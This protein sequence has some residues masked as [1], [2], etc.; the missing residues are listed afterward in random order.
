MTPSRA[1]GP[2]RWTLPLLAAVAVVLEVR[3]SVRHG[4]SDRPRIIV[5][6]ALEE[7]PDLFELF[8]FA[9][10][11]DY[12]RWVPIPALAWDGEPIES[13]P[14]ALWSNYE[15]PGRVIWLVRQAIGGPLDGTLFLSRFWF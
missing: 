8:A 5:P 9:P 13:M 12:D 14:V 10:D 2:T 7:S 1:V 6:G 3:S 4:L 15:G 11:A